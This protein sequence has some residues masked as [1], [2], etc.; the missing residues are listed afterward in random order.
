MSELIALNKID[1]NPFQPREAEDPE[2]VAN[3]AMSIVE[4]GLL[5]TPV[6]RQV[7]GRVQLAFGHTR[8]SA[9]R[10]LQSQGKTGYAAMPVVVQD[11]DDQHMFELTITENLARKDLTPIEEARAMKTY[12]EKFGKTSVE[13]GKLFGLS[14]SA[15][16]NKLRLLDLPEMVQEKIASKEITEGTARKLMVLEKVAPAEVEKMTE[17]L[18]SN[19]IDEGETVSSIIQRTIES[20][21]KEEKTG[22]IMWDG[23]WKS[24]EPHAGTG[25]WPLTWAPGVLDGVTPKQFRS[26]FPEWEEDESWILKK[27]RNHLAYYPNSSPQSMMVRDVAAGAPLELVEHGYQLLRPPAC[28]ACV[29]HHAVDG[30]HYCR[31]KVCWQNKRKAWY[32]QELE[33]LSQE[34]GI[35]IYDK[36]VDG[37]DCEEISYWWDDTSSTKKRWQKYIDEGANHLRLRIKYQDWRPH[38][39]TDSHV[40][41]LVSVR[42]EYQ[43]QQ[44]KR[45]QENEQKEAERKAEMDSWEIQR[46]NREW[47]TA[48]MWEV[49]APLFANAFVGIKSGVL[50]Y[51]ASAIAGFARRQ[52]E[53]PEDPKERDEFWMKFIAYHTFNDDIGHQDKGKG[54]V[55]VANYLQGVAKAWGVKLPDE[56]EEIAREFAIPEEEIAE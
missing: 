6:G 45:R 23:R 22:L 7:N 42:K 53:I 4:Q 14:D 13:I 31:I 12:R 27:V 32:Q 19:E 28:T 10:L 55:H 9:F 41:Q 21:I 35:S 38:P 25:L 56:F 20:T 34:M 29:Y 18:T 37:R 50:P 26:A 39:F 40:V 54:P 24:G 51:L 52:H 5:Q 8:L 47:S 11:L 16:R 36:K 43:K 46:R 1:P 33:K 3:V 17:Q 49:A 48:F 30:S 2:H 15:V 44:E